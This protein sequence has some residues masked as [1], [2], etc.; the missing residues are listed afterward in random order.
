[1]IN[2][3]R[4]FLSALLLI[5]SALWAPPGSAAELRSYGQNIRSLGMGG[6][7]IASGEEATVMLWNPAGL[8]FS[9]GLRLDLFDLGVGTNGYQTY[10]TFQ[11]IG[12]ISDLNSLGPLYGVPINLGLNGY[13]AASLPNFG[14]AVFSEGYT[15]MMFNN[16]AFP[17]LNVQYFNDYGYAIGGAFGTGGLGFGMTVKRIIRS[18]GI[19]TIGA[20]SLDGLDTSTLT[21]IFTDEGVG[22]GL[23]LGVMYKA[24]VIFSPTLSLAWQNV[25]QTQFQLS[26]GTV[27]PPG[28]RD[29]VSLGMSIDGSVG[30]AGMAAGFEYRHIG[31]QGEQLGKKIHMGLELSL[32]NMDFRAGFYQG[33]PT[34]GFGLDLFLFQFDAAL[35]TVERGVYPGQTPDQ[36]I[37]IGISSSW[38]FD[39][40]FNLISLGGKGRKL[41]QRR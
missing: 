5:L 8:H 12:T 32:L 22:Y 36:R 21:S 7:R 6:V 23:D 30:L 40:D 9:E 39:P 31:L 13:A 14:A 38:G 18:G 33:Y 20:E 4:L 37:N 19:Q 3:L 16:P 25:G 1:M 11:N 34:Y 35:H 10:E 41:K 2:R 26:K 28:I 29:N 27:T 24:P 17:E 15:D